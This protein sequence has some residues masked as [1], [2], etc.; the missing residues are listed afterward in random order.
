MKI[1]KAGRVGR[2]IK[3]MS[4]WNIIISMPLFMQIDVQ[5]DHQKDKGRENNTTYDEI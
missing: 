2:I 3:I 4:W 5:A 1:P